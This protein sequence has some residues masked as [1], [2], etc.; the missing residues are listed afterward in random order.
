LKKLPKYQVT[1]STQRLKLRPLS[2]SDVESIVTIHRDKEMSEMLS[3]S[4]PFPYTKDDAILFINKS[5]KNY[6]ENENIEFGITLKDDDTLIGIIGL[7]LNPK[8]DHVTLAFWI[9]K[10][11]WGEGYMSEAVA[12]V[13]RYCFEELDTH[14]VASHHFH[15]NIASGKVMQKVGLLCEGRRKEHYKK[16]DAFFDIIDYGV[17]E[18][19]W[20]KESKWQKKER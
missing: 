6:K 1:L 12:E 15:P 4:V 16:G 5:H 13:V 11:W 7:D 18:R 20:K 3:D 10:A 8:D 17:V 19:E 2:G 9:G 14:R